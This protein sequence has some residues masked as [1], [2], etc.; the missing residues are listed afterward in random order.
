MTTQTP[1][2]PRHPRDKPV[3]SASASERAGEGRRARAS[4]LGRAAWWCIAAFPA[5]LLVVMSVG[6]V[7]FGDG[8]WGSES[9]WES[10][11]LVV[12]Y[13]ALAAAPSA[14]LVLSSVAFRRTR[15]WHDLAPALAVLAF[16][17]GF[18]AVAPALSAS[19]NPNVWTWLVPPIGIAVWIAA[20]LAWA[21]Q[22]R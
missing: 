6:L 15:S 12:M 18:V 10:L 14:A 2:T 7:V 17:T 22:K 21:R 4:R 19:P 1:A 16:V 11:L 9:G 3:S 20:V 13:V 5:V 8:R